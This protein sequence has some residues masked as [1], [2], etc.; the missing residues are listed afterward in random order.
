ML[1]KST[2][3][4]FFA[5]ILVATA[6]FWIFCSFY[7]SHETNK[8]VSNYYEWRRG[9]ASTDDIKAQTMGLS[10]EFV[11]KALEIAASDLSPEDKEQS[12]LELESYFNVQALAVRGLGKYARKVKGADREAYVKSFKNYFFET[13]ADEILS[14]GEGVKAKSVGTT[15]AGKTITVK[16]KFVVDGEAQN[17]HLR[18]RDQKISDIMIQ[19]ISVLSLIKSDM[20]AR[21]KADGLS[22]FLKSFNTKYGI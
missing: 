19:N 5:G 13:Y 14:L 16:Y 21:I 12:F 3:I 11:D 7:H 15:A 17:V 2:F 8:Q 4:G 18:Y 20:K 6:G 22:G 9:I 1:N 10:K